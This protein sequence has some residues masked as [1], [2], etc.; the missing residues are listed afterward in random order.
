[1]HVANLRQLVHLDLSACLFLSIDAIDVPSD[2]R[3]P[4][5]SL[6]IGHRPDEVMERIGMSSLTII[7]L[8][9]ASP[10]F[11]ASDEGIAAFCDMD[12]GTTEV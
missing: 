9:L 3:S 7:H 10:N 1:M 2:G 11:C 4:I 12:T 6:S 5:T 8:A